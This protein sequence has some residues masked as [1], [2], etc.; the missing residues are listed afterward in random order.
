MVLDETDDLEVGVARVREALAHGILTRPETTR[1]G[2]V[3]HGNRRGSCTIRG[4][5]FPALKHTHADRRE[6]VWP[7]PVLGDVHVLARRGRVARNSERAR[8]AS[9][10]ER[11]QVCEADTL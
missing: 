2:L 8:I 6:I 3:D 5:E 4:P 1:Q 9:T 7:H 11:H 10:L